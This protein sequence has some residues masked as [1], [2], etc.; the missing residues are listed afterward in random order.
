MDF[1][2]TLRPFNC[3]TL[4]HSASA[5]E[6]DRTQNAEHPSN[7]SFMA[8][9]CLSAYQRLNCVNRLSVKHLAIG[10]CPLEIFV[11][12]DQGRKEEQFVIAPP[13]SGKN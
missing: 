12:G 6:E 13:D 8:K 3:S 10:A 7:K 5:A 9:G 1:D 11:R 4:C 2:S